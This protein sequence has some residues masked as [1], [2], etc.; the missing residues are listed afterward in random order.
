MLFGHLS[1]RARLP[2]AM[3]AI[4]IVTEAVVT[5]TLVNRAIRD[6]RADLNANA[7]SL[8]A[9]MS[10]SLRDP[11]L[12]DD[13]WQAFEIVR[14]PLRS[15]TQTD[16]LREILTLDQNGKIFAASD[17][18]RYQ[19]ATTVEVLTDIV[20]GD[21]ASAV[22]PLFKF[23]NH[24]EL[25]L[26]R[27]V[28]LNPIQT[29]DGSILGMVAIFYDSEIFTKRS[30]RAI[31]EVIWLSLPGMLILIPLAWFL[32]GR[33]A[34]PLSRLSESISKIGQESASSIRSRLPPPGKDEIGVLSQSAHTL[35]DEL[36]KK[37]ELQSQVMTSNRL[38]AVGRVAA[39][40][41]HEIKN[42]VGG[43]LNAVDTAMRHGRPDIFMQRTLG[44]IERGLDQI[45][46]TVSALLVE[47]RRDSPELTPQD[48][49]DLM[50]LIQPAADA[51]SLKC[52]W[53]VDF[54][55][56]DSVRLPA[57]D[58]R[59]IL[60]NLLLNAIE[61]AQRRPFDGVQA[62]QVQQHVI[63]VLVFVK[64]TERTLTL[65]VMNSGPPIP[66]EQRATLFEPFIFSEDKRSQTSYGLGLWVCYR[67]VSRLGGVIDVD[68]LDHLTRFSVALPVQVSSD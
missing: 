9:A 22:P 59:Q 2:L 53:E 1:W 25:G 10:R 29:D 46:A 65:K 60:L 26:N 13:V 30:L 47:A 21:I 11:L 56:F 12:R 5:I 51:G 6:S 40:I 44:L 14:L 42:P 16:P 38:A 34:L 19:T 67:I 49:D 35:L 17:P 3:I 66:D 23:L 7:R 54:N 61:A 8:S 27:L 50:V 20:A 57:H 48:I 52:H 43:M 15:L 36:E 39:G 41:A 24:D 45:L 37:A 31:R 63:D 64:V 28:A 32:G 4:V 58:V 55:Q 62:V 33:L 18:L 68:R